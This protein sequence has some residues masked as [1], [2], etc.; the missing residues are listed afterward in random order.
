MSDTI[1]VDASALPSDA[2]EEGSQ[3]E[4]EGRQG[5]VVS[6]V[7]GS[8]RVEVGRER[9]DLDSDFVVLGLG[10]LCYSVGLFV[11]GW[12]W[13]IF[14]N[15]GLR[16]VFEVVAA[17]RET[18]AM[19]ALGYLLVGW[20][21]IVAVRNGKR[22][23]SRLASVSERRTGL[24]PAGITGMQ[25]VGLTCLVSIALV[26]RLPGLEYGAYFPDTFRTPIVAKHMLEQGVLSFDAGLPTGFDFRTPSNRQYFR[27]APHTLL[28]L[29][30]FVVFG[31]TDVAARLPGVLIGLGAVGAMYGL[32]TTV[33]DRRTGAV[34]AGLLAVSGWSVA[35]STYVRNYMLYTGVFVLCLY[36]YAR[37]RKRRT[38]GRFVT[39]LL[40]LALLL[41]TSLQ[42]IIPFGVFVAVLAVDFVRVEERERILRYAVYFLLMVAGVLAFATPLPQSAAAFAQFAAYHFPS[43]LWPLVWVGVAAGM[44]TAAQTPLGRRLVILYLAP[45]LSLPLFIESVNRILYPRYTAAFYPGFVLFGSVLLIAVANWVLRRYLPAGSNVV[46]LQRPAVSLD[47]RQLVTVGVVALVVLSGFGFV[48]PGTGYTKSEVW[49]DNYD[50][51]TGEMV[52]WQSET[53]LNAREAFT[54]S[55]LFPYGTPGTEVAVLSNGAVDTYWYTKANI[56]TARDRYT[57]FWLASYDNLEKW[58]FGRD[59]T[60]YSPSVTQNVPGVTRYERH[61]GVPVVS[62]PEQLT[63]VRSEYAAGVV[64]VSEDYAGRLSQ[65]L[66][67]YLEQNLEVSYRTDHVTVYAWG[68]DRE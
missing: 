34:A 54:E 23:R 25:A 48:V 53:T 24:L 19:P 51:S 26:T 32:G 41:H 9:P 20:T 65:S 5:V 61:T 4:I 12:A 47:A 63:A 10:W 67:A 39:L 7:G 56:E 43:A 8:A 37:Y 15:L 46:S 42:A 1:T 52:T 17:F 2:R 58:S 68:A 66:R 31:A 3:V 38:D 57:P 22:I 50:S 18:P 45:F 28:L 6:V 14:G 64:I 60:T 27:G 49:P 30:S 35:F 62:Q 11:T 29:L 21:A 59:S 16:P 40:A 44:V 33:F 36:L 55:G 13:A